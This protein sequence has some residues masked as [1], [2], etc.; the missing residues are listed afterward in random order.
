MARRDHMLRNQHQVVPEVPKRWRTKKRMAPDLEKHVD[1]HAVASPNSGTSA[2]DILSESDSNN[3]PVRKK[4]RKIRNSPSTDEASPSESPPRKK[5]K[6][7]DPAPVDP[8]V[9]RVTKKKA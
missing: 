5:R 7:A 1:S 4:K 8:S 9:V 6:A 3:P 2:V